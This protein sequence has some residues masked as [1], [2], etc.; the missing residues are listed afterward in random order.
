MADEED[1]EL[2]EL[3]AEL[4]AI[5]ARLAKI[6]RKKDKTLIGVQ[7][8]IASLEV[9]YWMVKKEMAH[10]R[11][12][13]EKVHRCSLHADKKQTQVAQLAKQKSNDDNQKLM[14]KLDALRSKV[15]DFQRDSVRW[16]LI[17]A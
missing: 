14:D 9:D 1:H 13:A 17:G 8:E 16:D 5:N 7:M 2:P 12:Q 3:E 11:G 4:T 6:R 10:T 15:N